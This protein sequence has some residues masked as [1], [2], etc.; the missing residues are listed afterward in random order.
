MLSVRLFGVMKFALS[1][2]HYGWN[3]QPVAAGPGA[4]SSALSYHDQG[5][6]SCH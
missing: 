6:G 5:V 2:G 3:F 1:P 4:D